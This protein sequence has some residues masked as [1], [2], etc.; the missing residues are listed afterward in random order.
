MVK[1]K[2]SCL[3]G[4][5]TICSLLLSACTAGGI[6]ANDWIIGKYSSFSDFQSYCSELDDVVTLYLSSGIDQETY[7]SSLDQLDQKLSNMEAENEESDIKPGTF[8]ETTMEAKEAYDDIWSS[9]RSLITSMK[10]D[11]AVLDSKDAL[12]YLYLAYQEQLQND[13]AKYIEG[14][15]EAAGNRSNDGG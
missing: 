2:L 11:P 13:V 14:Y 3:C 12:S 8:T 10:T 6:P 7:L 9:L 4:Y 1:K 5:I 15:Q